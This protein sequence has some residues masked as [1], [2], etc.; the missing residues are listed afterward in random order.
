MENSESNSSLLVFSNKVWKNDGKRFIEEI[1]P[2]Y[3]D[4]KILLLDNNRLGIQGMTDIVRA[5]RERSMKSL[6]SL[7]I[8]EITRDEITPESARILSH[9]IISQDSGLH[10]VELRLTLNKLGNKGIGELSRILHPGGILQYL[11]IIFNEIDDQGLEGFSRALRMNETL[12][13]LSLMGNNLG[14][15]GINFL[16]QNLSQRTP[17]SIKLSNNKIGN[18]GAHSLSKLIILNKEGNFYHL[19]I[20]D[21]PI[22]TQGLQSL[23]EAL[24]VNLSI[25]TLLF[26]EGS[27]REISDLISQQTQINYEQSPISLYKKKKEYG[28]YIEM[29]R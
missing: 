15:R 2:K 25:T 24:L 7:M 16:S 26:D 9:A 19:D 27:N 12:K 22:T 23:A 20:R 14:N 5:F 28:K 17:Q 21:N 11:Y 29:I 4:L 8:L 13:E 18:H 6:P 1:L 10:L 3:P